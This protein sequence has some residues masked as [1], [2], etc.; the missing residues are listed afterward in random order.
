MKRRVAKHIEVVTDRD[1]VA[2]ADVE[3]LGTQRV[4]QTP[5]KP[6]KK[7]SNQSWKC[8]HCGQIFQGSL[9]RQMKHLLGN[10]WSK[11]G[12][13]IRDCVAIDKGQRQL[14]NEK[15]EEP[16]GVATRSSPRKRAREKVWEEIED[17]VDPG[18][19]APS[20]AAAPG[21]FGTYQLE[22]IVLLHA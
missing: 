8:I 14:L 15:R 2:Q 19:S 1:G 10:L 12:A 16:Y 20:M 21:L 17:S 9:T 4:G 7:Q 6:D 11:Q 22:P 18:S 5:N 13:G 3:D